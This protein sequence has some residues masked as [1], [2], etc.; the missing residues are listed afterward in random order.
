SSPRPGAY[1]VVEYVED[2]AAFLRH[3]C[4]EPAV[5]YGHS[6]GA[7]VALAVAGGSE[8]GCCKAVILEDPPFQTLGSNISDTVY[9]SQFRGMQPLAG[10]RHPVADI[11]RGLAEIQLV[12]P[13][14]GRRTRFGDVRDGVSL[15]FGARCLSQV[16]PEVLTPIVAGRWLEGYDLEAI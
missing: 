15:R 12:T 2:V 11:A 10:S 3:G 16:D 1:R 5:I 8:A 14:T 6:L 9:L 13:G 7:M 4:D